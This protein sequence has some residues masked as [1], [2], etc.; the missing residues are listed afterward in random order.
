MKTDFDKKGRIDTDQYNDIVQILAIDQPS[1]RRRWL[2]RSVN[3]A[4]ITVIVIG[5][6]LW[7]ASYNMHV[8]K[9]KVAEVRRDSLT[10]TVTATGTLKPINQVE[11]GSEVSGTIETVEVDYNDRV[12]QGQVLARLNTDQL[13]AEVL[14][15]KALLESAQ[16]KVQEAKASV[17]ETRLKFNRMQELSKKDLAPE[18]EFE[19]AQAEYFRAQA[20][21]ASARA[22]V[23]VARATLIAKQTDLDKATIR[24]PIN[25]IILARK[26]EP[27]QTVVASFQTPELFTL[28]EDL[29]R[30]ELHVDIDEADIGPIK[31]GQKA[32]FTVDTYL[33]RTFTAEITSVRYEPK[34]VER[35]VTYKALLSVDNSGLLLRPGMTATA[36]I[37]TQTVEDAILVPNGAL[38]FTPPGIEQATATAHA[39]ESDGREQR[40]WILSSND[41]PVPVPVTIGLTD[42]RNTEI[43]AGKLEPGMSLLIDEINE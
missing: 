22:Q 19:G 27:G 12:E 13:N 24:S 15:S 11:V 34:T 41:Q 30:M 32:I 42:G 2:R 9:F 21:E 8:P 1:M 4:I 36:N 5:I 33:D 3:L 37:V 40:V 38:R 39:T 20:V 28:A 35:I 6:G 43:L 25:G 10:V 31:V 14:E 23:S 26:V 29:T 17:V 7:I 18:Q 16:A